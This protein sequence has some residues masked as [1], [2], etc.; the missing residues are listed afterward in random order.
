MGIHG[1]FSKWV[2]GRIPRAFRV[3]NKKKVNEPFPEPSVVTCLDMNGIF[4]KAAAKVYGPFDDP[5]GLIQRK[6]PVERK[7][8]DVSTLTQDEAHTYH[9][10]EI[11]E[12]IQ[13]VL[14]ETRPQALV[15][16]V[17]GPALIAKQTQQRARR[18]MSS[19][20]TS[21]IRLKDGSIQDR[22]EITPGTPFMFKLDKAIKQWISTRP[23]PLIYYSSHAFPG[24]GE[25]KIMNLFRG[26]VGDDMEGRVFHHYLSSLEGGNVIIY[27]LDADLFLLSMVNVPSRF[28]CILLREGEGEY[29]DINQLK[30][31]L[32]REM[33]GRFPERW[34]HQKKEMELS[35]VLLMNLMGN[36][37]LPAN[38]SVFDIGESI[39]NALQIVSHIGPLSGL[40]GDLERPETA[41]VAIYT[42]NFLKFL[43]QLSE[44]EAWNFRKKLAYQRNFNGKGE[45]KMIIDPLLNA[46]FGNPGSLEEQMKNFHHRWIQN[47]TGL[48]ITPKNRSFV[49]QSVKDILLSYVIGL[50]WV[51][52][53][54]TFYITADPRYT[55][56]SFYAPTFTM[57]LRFIRQ[58][59]KGD[60]NV[61]VEPGPPSKWNNSILR[62]HLTVFPLRSKA[63]IPTAL[64]P[65][66]RRDGPL[67]HNYPDTVEVDDAGTF[68]PWHTTPLVP[69]ADLEAID[70]Q[71][72]RLDLEDPDLDMFRM[73]DYPVI[74]AVQED[75]FYELFSP[76][77]RGNQQF[78]FLFRPANR[79][80]L[81]NLKDFFG[82]I[83][84]G[85]Q[86]H[87]AQELFAELNALKKP[88]FNDDDMYA[89]LRKK[90][91]EITGRK[92]YIEEDYSERGS[93]R[94]R[95]IIPLV[96]AFYKVPSSKNSI[97]YLDTGCGNGEITAEVGKAL[98]LNK[99]ATLGC[100]VYLPNNVSEHITFTLLEERPDFLPYKTN[101]IDIVTS[102][103]V[104]HHIQQ[105]KVRLI[106]IHRVLKP[107]GLFIIRE[108]DCNSLPFF[109]MLDLVHGIYSRVLRDEN[110]QG[111][112]QTGYSFYRTT[113]DMV[114]L[115][116]SAGF[117]AVSVGRPFGINR[118][119]YAAFQKVE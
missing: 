75:V 85:P 15:M 100:D 5:L 18:F 20:E 87:Y 24:E 36:D 91:L 21:P 90:Y 83:K 41:R 111:E 54:Y 98:G 86:P 40:T 8:P 117:K 25:H 57:L 108:H 38:P 12:I 39:E 95:D 92:D 26:T 14:L 88:R 74:S 48:Q 6:P 107:N 79:P 27:G 58:E 105:I 115:I 31:Y 78:Q 16:C 103:M 110:E 80:L 112:F 70:R 30:S 116:E 50:K 53:Y 68:Q 34:N 113:K 61:Y 7:Y 99:E 32:R 52:Q 118:T 65:V 77:V 102:L 114:D 46:T 96:H 10:Q 119:Y 9:I 42:Q 55:Y 59:L 67:F 82:K 44:N 101:S 64:H 37:F 1:F 19:A 56:I 4:H 17:D 84:F 2:L 47:M 106:E 76:Y 22:N 72:D 3:V 66:L 45:A 29:A 51:L 23:V 62:Q 43:H 71:L 93:K 94:V 33:T 60:P 63:L 13:N 89:L 104:L 28:K 81:Q 73:V 69:R 97:V 11:L 109:V 35:F 49:E